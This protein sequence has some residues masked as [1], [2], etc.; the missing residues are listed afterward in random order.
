MSMKKASQLESG[1]RMKV[2]SHGLP[3]IGKVV[4]AFRSTDKVQH[5]GTGNITR[6]IHVVFDDAAESLLHPDELVEIVA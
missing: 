4:L 1:D 5:M 6:G 3:S 2:H